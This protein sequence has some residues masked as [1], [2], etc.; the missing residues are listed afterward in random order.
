MTLNG[1]SLEFQVSDYAYHEGEQVVVLEVESNERVEVGNEL[2]GATYWV[3][4]SE[5]S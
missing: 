3:A 5:L 4:M 2:T 1:I